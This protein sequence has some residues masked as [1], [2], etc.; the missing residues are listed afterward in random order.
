LLAFDDI[1]ALVHYRPCD[2]M[3]DAGLVRAGEGEHVSRHLGRVAARGE[4]KP[5][6]GRRPEAVRRLDAVG[7]RWATVVLFFVMG[8][9]SVIHETGDIWIGLLQLLV[10]VLGLGTLVQE[11]HRYTV[12]VPLIP[13]RGTLVLVDPGRRRLRVM[14]ALRLHL[15]LGVWTAWR[16]SGRS[17]LPLVVDV[18]PGAVTGIG[19]AMTRA[20]AQVRLDGAPWGEW[21]SWL[22]L[23]RDGGTH[24]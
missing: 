13:G 11:R 20:G 1:P 24:P 2:G 19:W 12:Q 9:G 15:G 21:A 18:D 17:Q 8:V 4:W 22:A 16:L 3:H 14:G 6:R 23:D 10:A 7:P 5:L